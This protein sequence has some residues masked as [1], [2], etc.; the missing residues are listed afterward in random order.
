MLYLNR[1]KKLVACSLDSSVSEDF[2]Q[3]FAHLQ[4][5]QN[6]LLKWLHPATSEAKPSPNTL[7]AEMPMGKSVFLLE[8]CK[9]ALSD[10]VIIATAVHFPLWA[11]LCHSCH[12]QLMP[13]PG[14]RR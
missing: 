7:E 9:C 2:V 1:L 8:V 10:K 5:A 3:A 4:E 12:A 14:A 6:V 11:K 13:E